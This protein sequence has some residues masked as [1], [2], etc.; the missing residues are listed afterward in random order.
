LFCSGIKKKLC[1][2]NLAEPLSSECNPSVHIAIL[3]AASL[4]MNVAKLAGIKSTP[5]VEFGGDFAGPQ[6]FSN[7]ERAYIIHFEFHWGS[8]NMEGRPTDK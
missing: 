2:R 6:N 5:V 1:F 8:F 4:A 3:Q 7:F